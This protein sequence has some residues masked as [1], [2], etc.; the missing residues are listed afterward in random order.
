MTQNEELQEFIDLISKKHMQSRDGKD[1]CYLGIE[2]MLHIFKNLNEQIDGQ[3]KI[4][5]G[6]SNHLEIFQNA[7]T[8][9]TRELVKKG[10]L[11]IREKRNL[12]LRNENALE[13]LITL[14]TRKKLINR[15]ELLIELK[16]KR[17]EHYNMIVHA[18]STG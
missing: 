2:D 4:I 3:R 8:I 10:H 16:K 5:Q 13:A 15:R 17:K 12:L 6:F 11:Q 1:N 9:L 7:L 14:L 18:T